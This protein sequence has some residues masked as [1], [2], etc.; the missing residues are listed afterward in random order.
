[1]WCDAS[2]LIVC[3]RR[4]EPEGNAACDMASVSAAGDVGTWGTCWLSSRKQMDRHVEVRGDFKGG[5]RALGARWVK[6][7]TGSPLRA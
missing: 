4:V 2:H 5:H 1:M 6:C 3:T 7:L